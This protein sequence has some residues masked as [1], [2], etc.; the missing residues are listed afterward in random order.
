MVVRKYK[1]KLPLLPVYEHEDG[2]GG[3]G[4][5]VDLQQQAFRM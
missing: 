2:D 1:T 5:D 4:S 3:V